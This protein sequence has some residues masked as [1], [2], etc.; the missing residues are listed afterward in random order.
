[1]LSE[2]Q[3]LL[4]TLSIKVQALKFGSF[5]LK[6]GRKSPYFFNAGAFNSGEALAI[7]AKNYVAVIMELQKRLLISGLF[8]PAYKGIPL[9]SAVATELFS[10]EKISLPWAFNRKEIKDHGEGGLLVGADLKGKNVLVI[11]DVLTAGTA[12]RESLKLLRQQG[13][14]PVA[15]MV[16]LDR[17]ELIN[18]SESALEAIARE[19]Q[20]HC[21]ALINL[22]NLLSYLEDNSQLQDNLSALRDYRRR[23]GLNS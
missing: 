14:K 5:I 7:L 12:V 8:G 13:A 3:R 22:D 4:L 2:Q 1:M 15:L 23:Y 18:N 19:E 9:V 17:Q 11:D 6:S 20:I 16:I 21:E 10:R